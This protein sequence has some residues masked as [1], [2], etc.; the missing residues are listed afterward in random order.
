MHGE[1]EGG[2]DR[3]TGGRGQEHRRPTARRSAGLATARHRGDVQDRDT[4]RPPSRHR[5]P[6]RC[7]P[8]QAGGSIRVQT[9]LRVACCSTARMSRPRSGPST[10]PGP[11]RH[12]AD[13]PSVRQTL[14]RWQ[15]AFAE[16][17][18]NVITEG[19]DQGTIVF[20]DAFRKF[21]LTASDEERARRRHAE[22][23]ARG[24]LDRAGRRAP[25]HAR[26]RQA[27]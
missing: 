9:C 8:R 23:L 22:H 17:E 1:V 6:G 15:R 13:S 24:S 14:I 3:R 19:R 11:R 20:P 18:G 5:P 21:Y 10:S 16:A 7:V 4:G 26:T 2:H 25:R 27:G 12:A